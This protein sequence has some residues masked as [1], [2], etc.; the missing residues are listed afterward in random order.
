MTTIKY[1]GKREIYRDGCYGTGLVFTIGET[2]NV[3]DDDIAR[4][5]LRHKDVYVAGDAEE[6]TGTAAK[7]AP[8]KKDDD[9]E[10]QQARDAIANMTKGSLVSYAK[11]NFSTDLDNRKSVADM[12]AQVIGLL[13]QFG[14]D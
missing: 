4:K 6:A 3:E 7:I 2:I 10:A 14:T 11:T 9:D 5:M 8:P 1:I 13:D 12:R